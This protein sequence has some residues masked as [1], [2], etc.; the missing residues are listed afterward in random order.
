MPAVNTDLMYQAMV[1]E[2]K[3]DWNQI[4]YWSRLLDWKNQTLTPKS[5]RDLPDAV[6][7][8]RAR[9]A[10]GDRHPTGGWRLDHRQHHGLLADAAGGGRASRRRQREGRQVSDPAAWLF[11]DRAR[12]VHRAPAADLSR[13]RAA[14][15]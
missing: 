15:I 5:G 13:V 8:H 2:V 6:L 12:W 3:G 11:G 1:R 10:H 9:R 7:Q 14:A 4:V